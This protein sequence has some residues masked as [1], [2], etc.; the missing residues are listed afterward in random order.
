MKGVSSYPNPAKESL[1]INSENK[2]MTKI[3]LF[4][5]LGNQI[6]VLNPNSRKTTIDVSNF[7]SGIYIAK[8]ATLSGTVSIK[9]IVE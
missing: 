8:I 4:D 5:I 1:T 3:V 6:T 9:L 7:T 2:L